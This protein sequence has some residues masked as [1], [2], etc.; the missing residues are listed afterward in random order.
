MHNEKGE[1]TLY[2][3]VQSLSHVQPFATP[4]TAAHQ[5]SLSITN[6]QSILKLVSITLVMPSNVLQSFPASES[7]PI[8]QFFSVG[9]QSIGVSALE[10]V[11]PMNIQVGMTGWIN[12]LDLLAV[13]GTLKSLL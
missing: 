8:S 13:Q 3:S 5:A 6:S 7:F 1:G 4:W 11:L 10:S 2:P 9:G 12:R